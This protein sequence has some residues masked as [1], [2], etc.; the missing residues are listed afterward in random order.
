MKQR[1]AM[2]FKPITKADWIKFAV[3]MLLTLSFCL[4]YYICCCFVGGTTSLIF[5]P[6]IISSGGPFGRAD[7]SLAIMAAKIF[8]MIVLQIWTGLLI[9]KLRVWLLSLPIQYLLCFTGRC[10]IHP[11]YAMVNA[12]LVAQVLVAQI[13]AVAVGLLIRYLIRKYNARIQAT[14]IA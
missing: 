1:L 5:K 10:L 3:F 9:S 4:F 12:Q 14:P 8:L 13:P 6:R 2:F 11:G 7:D